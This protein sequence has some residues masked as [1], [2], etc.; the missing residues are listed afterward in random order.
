MNQFKDMFLGR[1]KLPFKRATTSQK[2]VRTG[3]TDSTELL[4]ECGYETVVEQAAAIDSGRRGTEVTIVEEAAVVKDDQVVA[5]AAPVVVEQVTI[6]N[7]QFGF[8]S[9]ELTPAYR[10]ELDTVSE[11]L[12]PHRELLRS[13]VQTLKI[14]G[15]TDSQGPAEYNQQLSER[16]AQAVA[17]YLIEQDPTRADFIS[18]VGRGEADPI[19]SNDS[20]DGRRQNRRVVMEVLKR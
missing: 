4:E 7:V 18:A 6:N 20:E 2:C 1:G 10:A 14:V 5:L 12:R 13:G 16:R 9:A 8:D 3:D 11:I 15:H 17:D 19:A